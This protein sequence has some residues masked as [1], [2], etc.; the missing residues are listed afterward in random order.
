MSQSTL[1]RKQESLVAAIAKCDQALA[2][3]YARY[4]GEGK[5][6]LT[7]EDWAKHDAAEARIELKRWMLNNKLFASKCTQG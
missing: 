6:A 7:A 5:P 1:T 4:W 2:D 3:L